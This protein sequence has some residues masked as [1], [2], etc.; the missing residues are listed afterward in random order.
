[1][2]LI[3]L[4]DLRSSLE[5]SLKRRDGQNEFAINEHDEHCSL[6]GKL[7]FVSYNRT[8]HKQRVDPLPDGALNASCNKNA[9]D[10]L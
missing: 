1:M 6:N 10:K 2:N 4:D 8:H 7:I 5:S 3:K 9:G